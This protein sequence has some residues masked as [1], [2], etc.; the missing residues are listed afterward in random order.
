MKV[1]SKTVGSADTKRDIHIAVTRRNLLVDLGVRK[2]GYETLAYGRSSV[3]VSTHREHRTCL[4]SSMHL[5]PL[6]KIPTPA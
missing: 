6:K 2:S 5:Q 3:S 1:A 4:T